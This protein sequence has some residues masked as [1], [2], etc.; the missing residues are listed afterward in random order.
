MSFLQIKRL[1]SDPLEALRA[2]IASESELD[3]LRIDLV[4]Q[5]RAQGRSWEDIAIVLGMA[6][7]S[8]WEFYNVRVLDE[9]KNR[10]AENSELTEEEATQLAV[11]EVRSVR[12]SRRTK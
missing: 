6:R 5:S 12:H 3:A 10:V 8:V 2:V 7:Q 1:P 9:L 11:E 4:R